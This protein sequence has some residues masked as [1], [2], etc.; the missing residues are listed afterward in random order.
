MRM[1]AV[2]EL[3][4]TLLLSLCPVLKMTYSS[5]LELLLFFL[6]SEFDELHD[7]PTVTLESMNKIGS[8]ALLSLRRI[9]EASE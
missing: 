4:R 5:I 6:I 7:H 2:D 1:S 8:A 9:K 3:S